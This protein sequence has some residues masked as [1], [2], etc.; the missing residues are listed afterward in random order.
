MFEYAC[1]GVIEHLELVRFVDT[2]HR[3]IAMN[4][5]AASMTVWA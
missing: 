1:D 2:Q 3:S 4:T 5:P